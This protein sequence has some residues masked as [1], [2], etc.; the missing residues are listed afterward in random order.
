MH[1]NETSKNSWALLGIPATP[2]VSVLE[3]RVPIQNLSFLFQN[4][5]IKNFAFWFQIVVSISE[6]GLC[7][8]RS[9]SYSEFVVSLSEC[10]FHTANCISVSEAHFIFRM[11]SLFQNFG[12]HSV[13]P[14]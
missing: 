6:C 12:G 10:S 8:G 5:A 9:H 2:T 1:N 4:C 11:P 14:Y 3:D 7:F 13:P